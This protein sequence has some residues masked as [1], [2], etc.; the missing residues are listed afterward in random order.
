MRPIYYLLSIFLNITLVG[1]D[2]EPSR[3]VDLDDLVLR[4]SLWYEKFSDIPYSGQMY[5]WSDEGQLK[6][7]GLIVDGKK[8]GLH[9]KF[10]QNGEVDYK[11]NY[12]NGKANGLYELYHY[13]GALYVRIIYKDG[14]KEIEEEF[15]EDGTLSWRRTYKNEKING[16]FESFH[17]DGSIRLR[18]NYT[19]GYQDGLREQFNK[20][21][22]KYY[23]KCFRL[24]TEVDLSFCRK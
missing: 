22:E 12:K 2:Q 4:D 19:D 20:D 10:K 15:F 8:D 1:C 11:L 23:Q 14:Q 24:N 13:G 9:K 18:A 17:E 5:D 7:K 3:E 21:G 16:L 6:Y